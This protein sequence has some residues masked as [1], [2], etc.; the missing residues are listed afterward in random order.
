MP[1]QDLAVGGT[2]AVAGAG[3]LSGLGDLLASGGQSIL[4]FVGLDWV[5]ASPADLAESALQEQGADA[6]QLVITVA[7]G[8]AGG[9]ASVK[10][11]NHSI[12]AGKIA[13][14]LA[15]I[16]ASFVEITT[17]LGTVFTPE[18]GLQ[19]KDA[20]DPYSYEIIKNALEEN[21]E[22]VPEPSNPAANK[23]T[24]LG[25]EIVATGALTG[26]TGVL[27]GL[28]SIGQ[29]GIASSL[30]GTPLIPITSTGTVTVAG[31]AP[32]YYMQLKIINTS[33]QIINF[34]MQFAK[35][36]IFGA[37]DVE[38]GAILLRS[39]LD[40]VSVQVNQ[41]AL[42]ATGRP[43]PEPRT[44]ARDPNLFDIIRNTLSGQ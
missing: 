24:T 23:I 26:A 33:L 32:N 2:S 14:Q 30:L 17:M 36:N 11:P 34:C 13:I 4:D 5:G 7:P 22:T 35:E 41:D 25:T 38:A 29:L 43:V 19:I 18:G 39:V 16:A 44:P 31:I 27:Q 20:L 12:D 10:L 3:D 21:G 8:T 6:S 40:D 1:I 9:T 37:V 42:E 28:S 15:G